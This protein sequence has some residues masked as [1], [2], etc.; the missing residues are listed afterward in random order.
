MV[1]SCLAHKLSELELIHT[2]PLERNGDVEWP[3]KENTQAFYR[4][5]YTNTAI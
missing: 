1:F 2:V 3:N 4:P 5:G